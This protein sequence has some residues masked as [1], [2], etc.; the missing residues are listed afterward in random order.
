MSVLIRLIGLIA[1]REK[2]TGRDITSR[3]IVSVLRHQLR[4]SSLSSLQATSCCLVLG[5]HL[6]IPFFLR[7]RD[8]DSWKVRDLGR[9]DRRGSGQSIH[10]RVDRAGLAQRGVVFVAFRMDKYIQTRPG[11]SGE[12]AS[13]AQNDLPADANPVVRRI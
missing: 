5:G 6:Y 1:L 13:E 10:G 2:R 7:R 4:Q 8:I 3:A 11:G 12:R 9:P